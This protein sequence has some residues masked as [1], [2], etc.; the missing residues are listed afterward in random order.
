MLEYM[1]DFFQSWFVYPGLSWYHALIA[2]G[3][4]FAFGAAWFAAYWTPIL[5]KPW[6]WAILAGSAILTLVAVTFAQIP[7]QWWT[8]QALNHFWSQD[9]LFD[10]LLL[11]GIPTILLSGL[12]QEGSKL[13][14]VVVYWWRK[15]RNLDPRTGLIIGAVAGLGFGV[16]EAVWVHNTIFAYGWT[17]SAVQVGGV[18]A[19]AAF[20]ERLFA[21]G[22]H[23]AASALAGYGLAKGWGWQFYLIAAFAHAFL[24]YS[25]ILLQLGHVTVIQLEILIAVWAALVTA[26]A[27][28]L[29]WRK[30]AGLTP[31]EVSPPQ[32]SEA[33]PV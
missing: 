1:L 10:W 12:V 24:N 3:L 22:F 26:V 2:I 29:R 33:K 17:W 21:V 25:V 18:V 14:P 16:F 31:G 15:G 8:S 13:V 23:I 27:L 30:S 4:A 6:A 11:V 28:W 20:W 19:L 32:T 7:L 5:R 9:I